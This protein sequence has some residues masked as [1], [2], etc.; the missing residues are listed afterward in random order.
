MHEECGSAR[1][2]NDRQGRGDRPPERADTALCLAG[3]ASLLTASPPSSAALYAM[4]HGRSSALPCC[5]SLI[6]RSKNPCL[7]P[8]LLLPF[9]DA[10]RSH[11][12]TA[13]L[14]AARPRPSPRARR[15]PDGRGP[16]VVRPLDPFPSSGWACTPAS[17]PASRPPAVHR[18]AS[19]TPRF[20]LREAEDRRQD[21]LETSLCRRKSIAPREPTSCASASVRGCRTQQQRPCLQFTR[22]NPPPDQ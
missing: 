17:Q 19:L 12:A 14:P 18:A 5:W 7:L 2:T 9:L 3:A 10:S 21:R 16:S 15:T 8:I 4:R 13:A 20:C 11:L 1:R 22:P 6:P